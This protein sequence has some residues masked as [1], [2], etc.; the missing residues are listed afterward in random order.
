MGPDFRD[1][2]VARRFR[3][4]FKRRY[5]V[6]LTLANLASSVS[7]RM[8]PTIRISSSNCG[9]TMPKRWVPCTRSHLNLSLGSVL[10]AVRAKRPCVK[11]S[12]GGTASSIVH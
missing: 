11:H 5:F 10:L 4:I 12:W 7:T 9:H 8:T 6:M 2:G 1:Y 3:Q